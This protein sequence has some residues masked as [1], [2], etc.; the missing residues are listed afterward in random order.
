MCKLAGKDHSVAAG[1]VQGGEL[2]KRAD[3]SRLI[4]ASYVD[5]GTIEFLD[6]IKLIAF[7]AERMMIRV[8]L[9]HVPDY[10]RADSILREIFKGRQTWCRTFSKGR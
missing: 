4:R 6:A 7:R 8:L 3:D 10:E 1:Y 9:E 5:S 2:A